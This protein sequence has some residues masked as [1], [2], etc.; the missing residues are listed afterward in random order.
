[1][2]STKAKVYNLADAWIL[3]VIAKDDLDSK[4]FVKLTVPLMLGYHLFFWNTCKC[5][6]NRVRRWKLW[7]LIPFEARRCLLLDLVRVRDK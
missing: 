1:M 5:N 7:F 6:C 4:K 3:F 2:C